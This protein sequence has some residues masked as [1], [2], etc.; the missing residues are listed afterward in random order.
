MASEFAFVS[1]KNALEVA[2]P[3]AS[4]EILLVNASGTFTPETHDFVDD[5]VANELSG[6]GYVR[7][8]L[9]AAAWT[10]SAAGIKLDANDLTW[11]G[12][13]AGTIGAAFIYHNAGGADSANK[14]VA[15]LDGTN[16][17]T[18]GGDVTV[19]FPLGGIGTINT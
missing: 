9:V 4:L 12:L 5:I 3:G 11:T 2:M 18:N 14:I 8:A 17:V 15:F 13:D 19:A 10:V 16:L 6:T 1:I 7:K